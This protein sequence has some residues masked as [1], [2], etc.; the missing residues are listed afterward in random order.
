M[1]GRGN[2][3]INRRLGAQSWKQSLLPDRDSLTSDL[4]PCVSEPLGFTL[5]VEGRF[6]HLAI[7]FSFRLTL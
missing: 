1:K 4:I 2:Q 7:E 6:P 3:F 5:Q